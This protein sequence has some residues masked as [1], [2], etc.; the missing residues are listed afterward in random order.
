MK[1]E[2]THGKGTRVSSV[3]WD[4]FTVVKALY[5]SIYLGYALLIEMK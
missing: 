3:Q 4:F 1:Q 2:M 5:I